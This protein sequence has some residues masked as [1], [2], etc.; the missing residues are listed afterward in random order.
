MVIRRDSCSNGRVF[1]S[2]CCILNGHNIF[3][4]IFV[5]RIVIFVWGD[6]NKRK[7]GR[8]WQVFFNKSIEV[9]VD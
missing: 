7:R 5:V 9:N 4:R 6:E 2:R 8:G 3:S 1:E